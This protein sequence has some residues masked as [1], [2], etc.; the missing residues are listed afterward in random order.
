MNQITYIHIYIYTNTQSPFI[1]TQTN[2]STHVQTTVTL[3][4]NC[5]KLFIP[6]GTMGFLNCDKNQL[7]FRCPYFI[8]LLYFSLLQTA[9]ESAQFQC[10]RNKI[11]KNLLLL[12][13][14]LNINNCSF[15]NFP[16]ITISQ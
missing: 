10:A 14:N 4:I 16:R 3:K 8:S 1:Y 5:L 6:H 9:F 13:N 2:T 12:L 15:K 7:S 11:H